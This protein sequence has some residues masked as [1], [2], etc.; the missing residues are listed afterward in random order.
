MHMLGETLEASGQDRIKSAPVVGQEQVRAF[1]L[2]ELPGPAKDS[3]GLLASRA[4]Q[5]LGLDP[6]VE[7]LSR[8][9]AIV[10][11]HDG[12]PVLSPQTL[13]QLHRAQL[14]SSR[15]KGAENVQGV[16]HGGSQ[17]FAAEVLGVGSASRSR[18]WVA[19]PSDSGAACSSF[20]EA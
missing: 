11:S 9:Q 20:T 16:G 4:G 19:F 12:V 3:C 13:D 14:R 7:A 8:V 15:G 6:R 5:G 2:Q 10:H 18:A 17:E 1:A